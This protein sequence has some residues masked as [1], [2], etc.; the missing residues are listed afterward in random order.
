MSNVT[1][2]C[3]PKSFTGHN[4][5]IQHNALNNWFNI[6]S[7]DVILLGPDA[8]I[9]EAAQQYNFKHIPEIALSEHGTPLLDDMFNKA[10]AFSSTSLVCYINADILLPQDFALVAD[11]IA[12]QF[13]RFLLVGSRWNVDVADALDF[14]NGFSCLEAIRLANGV[15]HPPTGSDYFLF[16]RGMIDYMRPFRIGRPGWDNWLMGTTLKR[17][18]PLI[19][20]SE[21]I[22]ILHQNHDY[23]HVPGGTGERW[24]GAPESAQNYALMGNDGDVDGTFCIIA[25]ASHKLKKDTTKVYSMFAFYSAIKK[26]IKT[27]LPIKA[28]RKIYHLIKRK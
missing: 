21:R 23:K 24:V 10:Q 3:C 8:G 15:P 1:L 7:A 18:I 14:S 22:T 4:A 19:D 20:G 27:S 26:N 11:A 5:L 13:Q 6:E 2:F 28:L 9:A 17:G 12:R 16:P 25:N